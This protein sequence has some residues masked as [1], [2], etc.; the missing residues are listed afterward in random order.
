MQPSP[1][2]QAWRPD[3]PGVS[4]V[5]HAY[6]PDHAYPLHTHDTWTLLLVDAGAFATTWS[7]TSTPPWAPG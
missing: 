2:V 1:T 3:V 4:E 7:G 6:F 5:L